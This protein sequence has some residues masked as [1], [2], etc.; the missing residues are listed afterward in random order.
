MQKIKN[1]F[2]IITAA[3]VFMML[4]ASPMQAYATSLVERFAPNSKSL[5]FYNTHTN[6]T[7]DV[8]FMRDGRYDH[9]AMEE[10]NDYLRDHRNGHVHS[11]S[12]DLMNLLYDIK[13]E[14]HRRH[15]T[16]P[17]VF[18]VISGFRSPATNE[19]LRAN[20]GGQAKKSRHMSGDAIDIRVP[21]IS[22]EEIRNVAWCMQ[23][24]GVGYYK[25]SDF[26]HVDTWKVRKWNWSPTPGL[27]GN[28]KSS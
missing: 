6:E 16:T 11:M 26:V 24:G 27:C 3:A 13:T 4:T 1:I 22:T 28:N 19:M 17:V 7:L 9:M 20:G 25:G 10:V 21:G 5:Q 2:Q 23:R 12:T 8:T 15:P 18:H 14:L